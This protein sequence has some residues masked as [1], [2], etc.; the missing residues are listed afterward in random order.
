MEQPR[1]ADRCRNCGC[2]SQKA[3]SRATAEQESAQPQQKSAQPQ[4]GTACGQQNATAGPT[5]SRRPEDKRG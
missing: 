4:Q 1:Q 5:P 2:N 3:A